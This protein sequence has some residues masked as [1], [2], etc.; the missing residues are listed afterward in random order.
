M[1]ID[2]S[3]ISSF[4]LATERAAYGASLHKGKNDKIAADQA[5]VNE[6]RDVL[7]SI[8]MI[9]KIVIGE[10]EMDEAPMLYINEKVGTNNGQ[11][12]DIAV[13]PLEGT[14]FLSK[15][16][17]NSLSV[18]AATKDGNMLNA[19]DMYMEKLAFGPNLPKN[20]LDLDYSVEKNINF[21]AKA[22]NK[23][24]ED[25]NV[26]LLDRKR[27]NKIIKILKTLNVNI[28]FIDDGDV[29]GAI[30]VGYP[31]ACVDL[32]IGTGGAPEGVLAAAA[33]SCMDCQMQTRLVYEN[34][35]DKN[36]ARSLGILDFYK[37]YNINDMING[38]VIFAATGV[39]DGD[40]V[41]GIRDEGNFFVSETLVLHKSANVNRII[42]NK[43]KK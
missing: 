8:N 1:T 11:K 43:I 26:C 38:D 7:N 16:M 20:L 35:N 29:S 13:D 23:K 6:M 40:F 36:R 4:S 34:D 33:L 37:K 17:P 24:I 9:G 27:H 10:G 3:F 2:K 28:K 14:N 25:L 15:N 21:L 22:K 12:F 19:P 5:A 30:S 39:T 42:M 41:K 32:Y 18:I 31:T